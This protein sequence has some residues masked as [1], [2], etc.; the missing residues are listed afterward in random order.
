MSITKGATV[1]RTSKGTEL[2]IMSLKG[3]PYLVVA[4][5]LVW[6]REE[7]PT[8]SIETSFMTVT[9][10]HAIAYAKVYIDGKLVS[11][12]TKRESVDNFADYIEK[13]E[14]GAIGRALAAAG[15]GTQ[16]TGDE[17]E[18]GERIVD[19]PIAPAKRVSVSKAS[20]IPTTATTLSAEALKE[21]IKLLVTQAEIQGLTTTNAFRDEVLGKKYGVKKLADLDSNSA[22][23]IL[24]ELKTAYPQLVNGNGA[25]HA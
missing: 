21:T 6:F 9:E 5:R 19:S 18:E 11:T 25:V 2:P 17:L 3:K 24:G 12:G 13:A 4:Y 8:G 14:T 1:A 10:N 7:H 15:Y 23:Q 20:A 22:M 16:F